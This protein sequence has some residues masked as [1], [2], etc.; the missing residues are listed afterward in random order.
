MALSVN[1]IDTQSDSIGWLSGPGGVRLFI[2]HWAQVKPGLDKPLAVLQVV[3]GMA[4]HSLRYGRLARRLCA[5]GIEV[6]A[7]DLRGHGCTA[8]L[9]INDAGWGGLK[10][11]CADYDGFSLVTQDIDAL[12]G[13]IREKRPGVPLFLLGHSWGSFLTQHYIETHHTNATGSGLSGCI[14][15]GTRGPDGLKVRLGAKLLVFLARLKGV[16]RYSA[17][18]RAAADGPYNKPFRPNRTSFD[19]LSRDNDEVD[20]FAHDPLCGTPCSSGFYRDLAALLELIHRPDQMERI[21]R[22]LP[23]YVFSGSADP[24]G[25]MGASPTAL[26]D[27]Y[28]AMGVGDLEFVLYPDARHE[29]LNE[30]NR[31]EVMDNLLTWMLKHIPGSENTVG[32]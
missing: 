3:H 28:R 26:V 1:E 5:Q 19:W 2:R 18:A 11:H 24:V 20:Q 10:G 7:M 27:A 30:T 8:D 15:S 16:R 29:P 4:E 17:I 25:E 13:F 31:E 6:W 12:N 32:K 23:V 9:S 14:L 21:D 22:R